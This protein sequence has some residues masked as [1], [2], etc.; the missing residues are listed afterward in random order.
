MWVACKE[1]ES[2]SIPKCN[3]CNRCG[4]KKRCAKKGLCKNPKWVG[5]SPMPNASSANSPASSSHPP[6]D[7]S[8]DI[9]SL[10]TDS[11]P[12]S[13]SPN[14]SSVS[15]TMSSPPNAASGD[16]ASSSTSFP[17][18]AALFPSIASRL[19]SV[20]GFG[21]TTSSSLSSG[22]PGRSKAKTGAKRIPPSQEAAPKKRRKTLQDEHEK[23]LN[24]EKAY[25]EVVKDQQGLAKVK[26]K[27]RKC[28]RVEKCRINCIR[29]ASKCGERGRKIHKR[30]KSLK[31]HPC[32]I[33]GH[34][35]TT[36]IK[37]MKHRQKAHMGILRRPR[38]WKC[39]LFFSTTK[40][41]RYV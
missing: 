15:P 33:C 34:Q 36:R 9:A 21:D 19:E 24:V 38:C 22:R 25:V 26:Y 39:N 23:M 30:G 16:T 5:K 35:E 29:H 28:D 14:L 12:S 27:C 17:S 8:G 10:L 4:S 11:Q 32:N 40:S 37:L 31:K 41:Y 7:A 20:A 6:N 1:C 2:C 18:V 13:R 3:S